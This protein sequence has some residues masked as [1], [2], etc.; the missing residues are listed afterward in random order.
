MSRLPNA[1]YRLIGTD[2][3]PLFP[4]A[5]PDFGQQGP[6]S[7]PRGSMLWDAVAAI[8]ISVIVLVVFL[9]LAVPR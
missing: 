8:A 9:L 4:D 3:R 2:Y 5:P 6:S 1:D 7:L